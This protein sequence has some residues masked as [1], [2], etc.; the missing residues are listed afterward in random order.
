VDLIQ[1]FIGA[2][3]WQRNLQCLKVGGRL[4][5]VGLMGG[6]RVEADLG[7]ILRQRLQVIG[8]VMRSQPLANKVAIT[9]RFCE[10]WLPLLESGVI[11][12]I[13]DTTFPLARAA[14]AH[15]YMEEN[16]NVGKIV[17]VVS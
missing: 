1:D 4:V 6:A 15:R 10:R 2:A 16:R 7:L 14:A 8:S 5:L 11:R 9:R 12:P 17:L 3:Y 13:I